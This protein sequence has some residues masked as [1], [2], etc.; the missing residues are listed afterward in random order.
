MGGGKN[1]APAAPKVE[2]APDIY[3]N[4]GKT[5][6]RTITGPDGKKQ[7]IIERMPLTPEEKSAEDNLKRLTEENLQR[8]ERLSGIAMAVDIPE[9]ADTV[10]RLRTE[11]TRIREQ[12]FREGNRLQEQGLARSGLQDSSSAAAARN[13]ERQ[14]L[15]DTARTDENNLNLLAEDLRTAALGRTKELLN[16]GVGLSETQANRLNQAAQFGAGLS[17][18][19]FSSYN[20]ANQAAYANQLAAFNSR[21]P[22]FGSQLL[23]AAGTLGAAY[24]GGPAMLGGSLFGGA[25]AAGLGTSGWINPNSGARTYL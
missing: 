10:G 14:A 20:T 1:K 11:Q 15:V 21:K 22:S 25:G 2:P 4:I 12:T 18:Q 17:Q 6:T 19:S 8:F 24:L 3:D 7:T 23:G 9:F 5:I 16:L 13:T